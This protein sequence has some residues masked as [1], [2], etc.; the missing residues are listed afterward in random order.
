THPEWLGLLA[1]AGGEPGIRRVGLQT[2][3]ILLSRAAVSA[4]AGLGLPDLRF[5]VSLEGARPES[6]D[7]VRGAGS[8]AAA[9]AGL[10]RLAEAGLGPNTWVAFTELR[11]NL[12]ELPELLELAQAL[13]LAGVTSA[14]VVARGRARGSELGP[15]EPEQYRA[16]LARH[17]GDPVF[18]LRCD[19]LGRVAALAWWQGRGAP[20]AEAGCTFLEN[21]YVDADGRVY[22]CVL[23]Q[24]RPWA[25][26]GAL[27]RP[28]A[29]VVAGAL[30]GWAE[31]QALS[32]RRGG[33]VAACRTCP[34]REPC[35]GGC[36]GRAWEAHGAV[37]APEDRCRLRRAVYETAP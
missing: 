2:N 37:L 13:G 26:P 15:P 9:L 18:R 14:P 36:L 7:R 25:A 19:R 28:L 4:L 30:E 6:H 22:P 17:R 27:E 10:R 1:A 5:Q 32:R 11:H 23:F 21:P 34:G 16:L 35:A 3:G 24:A 31:L 33:E 20:R 8:F 29:D 12:E